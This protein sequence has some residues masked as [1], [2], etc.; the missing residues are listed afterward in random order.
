MESHYGQERVCPINTFKVHYPYCVAWGRPLF[1]VFCLQ[2]IGASMIEVYEAFQ[3]EVGVASQ[4]S[5]IP[6]PDSEGLGEG[7]H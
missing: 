4:P 2:V 5:V 6:V 3:Q 7:K 1:E